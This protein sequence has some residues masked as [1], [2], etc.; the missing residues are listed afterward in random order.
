[1]SNCYRNPVLAKM[2]QKDFEYLIPMWR[3]LFPGTRK[4]VEVAADEFFI[5]AGITP[6]PL[7]RENKSLEIFVDTRINNPQW[8]ARLLRYFGAG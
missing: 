6:R 5:E 1:M 2:E 3:G 7:Q 4:E 8:R